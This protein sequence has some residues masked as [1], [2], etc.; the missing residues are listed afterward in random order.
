MNFCSFEGS[1]FELY[2][3]F[4]RNFLG[5]VTLNDLNRT[6]FKGRVNIFVFKRNLLKTQNNE[7]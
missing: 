2:R 7:N 6:F 5:K 1:K 4:D 3:T